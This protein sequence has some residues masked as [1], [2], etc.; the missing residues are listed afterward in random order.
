MVQTS[1]PLYILVMNELIINEKEIERE[2]Q[3]FRPDVMHKYTL[4]SHKLLF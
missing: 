1:S 4:S 2:I 3:L